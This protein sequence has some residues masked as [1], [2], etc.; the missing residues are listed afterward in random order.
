[1]RDKKREQLKRVKLLTIDEYS[2]L[3][4]DYFYQIHLRLQ[5]IKMNNLMFGGVSVILLGNIL[6]LRP[7]RGN[8]I[9]EE[10]SLEAWKS[11]FDFLDLWSTFL[12]DLQQLLLTL[13]D[14]P[15]I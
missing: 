13:Q 15:I 3:K 11:G 1:M 4:S 2:M 7:V 8:F 6:Q 10:P 14:C 5:E 12:P 9:F